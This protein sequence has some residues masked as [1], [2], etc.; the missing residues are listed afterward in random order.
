MITRRSFSTLGWV[1]VFALCCAS[2]PGVTGA[3]TG[4]ISSGKS[5]PVGIRFVLEESNGQLTGR[6]YVQD[7]GTD[8]YAIEAT[9]SGTKNGANATWTSETDVI[10]KGKFEDNKFV[11]TIEFPSDQG[12]PPAVGT[13]TL[14]Q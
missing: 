6:T 11:G 7:Q 12:R 8:E 4:T 5:K 9:I 1:V 10:V 13:L 14:S 3:W 2:R